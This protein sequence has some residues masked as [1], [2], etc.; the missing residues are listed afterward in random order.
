MPKKNSHNEK[1]KQKESPTNEWDHIT[2][3][4]G[5]ESK[6]EISDAVGVQDRKIPF[7]ANEAILNEV[8]PTT[9]VIREELKDASKE[10]RDAD[11]YV[12]YVNAFLSKRLSDIQEI[13]EKKKRFDEE[14][15]AL[16]PAHLR[17]FE[18]LS[19][20]PINQLS[21]RETSILLNGLSQE[22]ENI[23]MRLEHYKSKVVSTM[24]ILELHD[25]K[26]NEVYNHLQE[27]I[28]EEK[29]N[30]GK[31][32]VETIHAELKS[33]EKLYGMQNLSEALKKLKELKE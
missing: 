9:E 6:I 33:L 21:S 20:L 3:A 29:E 24:N 11:Q 12:K 14:I 26:M 18:K 25:K 19:R 30:K 22:R 2:S 17:G 28:T 32:P 10:T 7:S 13:Q 23:I 31:M 1:K 4:E 8:V 16:K 27:K 15:E 5:Y